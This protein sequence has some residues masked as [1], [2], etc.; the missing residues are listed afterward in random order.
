M[1]QKVTISP[2]NILSG[3][4]EQ[5]R[6]LLQ[7]LASVKKDVDLNV[8][9]P[10]DEALLQAYPKD[11][12]WMYFVAL[13]FDTALKRSALDPVLLQVM[14]PVRQA[15]IRLSL[16]DGQLLS[17]DNHVARRLLA[18]LYSS[19]APWYEGLGDAGEAYKQAF[20]RSVQAFEDVPS[21]QDP[22]IWERELTTF[23]RF[24]AEEQAQVTQLHAR[25]A[26][27][28]E[29][30]MSVESAEQKILQ[31]LNSRVAGKQIPA[32]LLEFL[33]QDFKE[34]LLHLA[35]KQGRIDPLLR[36]WRSLLEFFV[37]I[38]DAENVQKDPQRAFSLGPMLISQLTE[39]MEQTFKEPVKEGADD[40]QEL[41][42]RFE[43]MMVEVL[44]GKPPECVLA[45]ELKVPEAA[46]G[47]IFCQVTM[48]QMDVV[49]EGDW[50]RFKTADKRS[51]RC[52]LLKKFEDD[53]Q[54]LFVNRNGTRV[55]RKGAQKVIEGIEAKAIVKLLIGGDVLT[56]A[57]KKH[58]SALLKQFMAGR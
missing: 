41:L 16:Q 30:I 7:A 23:E 34:Q 36:R 50:F 31:M 27:R 22:A 12:R 21:Q 44:K 37:W 15:F 2:K 11:H 4:G 32:F 49:S 13:V 42:A 8:N 47:A 51:L 18:L 56:D 40:Q 28:E 24:L 26:A 9:E 33:Y 19:G 39:L 3:D 5:I 53:D 1:N 58:A 25:V 38:C 55:M 6:M 35:K 57:L 14:P 43:V 54:W 45:P 46:G 29:A 52:M 17:D 20:C 48:G 10:L